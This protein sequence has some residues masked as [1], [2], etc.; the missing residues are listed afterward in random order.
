MILWHDCTIKVNND[1]LYIMLC[2]VCYKL[3]D[4][5]GFLGRWYICRENSRTWQL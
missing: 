1:I 2:V 4:S 3:T 5:C